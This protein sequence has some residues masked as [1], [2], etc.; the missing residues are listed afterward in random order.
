MNPTVTRKLHAATAPDLNDKFLSVCRKNLP[1]PGSTVWLS[2]ATADREFLERAT[3]LEIVDATPEGR[4]ELSKRILQYPI[5]ITRKSS[6]KKLKGLLRAVLASR[7]D[8]RRAGIITHSTLKSNAKQL[9]TMFDDRVTM[10]EY[11]GS[12]EDRASNR[13]HQSRCELLIVAGTPRIGD[14]EI[15]KQLLRVGHEDAINSGGDC[16]SWA[17]RDSRRRVR[18][19]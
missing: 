6:G 17:G 11:F 8:C 1:T 5:D 10:V 2:D 4:P 3:G 13:W 15:R 16:G 9:G 7:R 18:R 12:D 19:G 14:M